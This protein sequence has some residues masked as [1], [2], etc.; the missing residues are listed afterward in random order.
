M[1]R[2]ASCTCGSLAL[3]VHGYPKK[4]SVCHCDA[5]QHRTGSSFGVAVFFETEV[6][7]ECGQASVY[8]RISDSGQPLD[9]YFCPICGST[10]F[11]KPKFRPGLTAAALG[12]FDNNRGWNRPKQY[13]AKIGINGSRSSSSPYRNLGVARQSATMPGEADTTMA[14]F[15][16]GWHILSGGI[17]YKDEPKASSARN[18]SVDRQAPQTRKRPSQGNYRY[19]RDGSPLPRHCPA[20]PCR[21]ES[22]CSRQKDPDSGSPRPLP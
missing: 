6:T 4:V 14:G 2:K 20:A 17:A 15:A 8:R 18:P 21:R 16:T 3:V 11:W 9:F 5:C 22:Y 13:I 19:D 7:E 1:K 12:C 10:V